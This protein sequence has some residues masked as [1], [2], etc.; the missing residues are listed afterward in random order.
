MKRRNLKCLVSDNECFIRLYFVL[1]FLVVATRYW[2]DSTGRQQLNRTDPWKNDID[3]P[4]NADRGYLLRCQCKSV[5]FLKEVTIR[6]NS[7]KQERKSAITFRKLHPFG[8]AHETGSTIVVA[9]ISTKNVAK[10]KP[11]PAKISTLL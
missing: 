5:I 8:L 11:Y 4:I 7:G 6:Q 9:V 3:C 1:I 2:G 10:N